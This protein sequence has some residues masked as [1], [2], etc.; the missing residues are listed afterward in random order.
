V[1]RP[2]WRT[3]RAA[4]LACAFRDRGIAVALGG[5]H[6]SGSLAMLP[7][8]APEIRALMERGVAVV[9][10]EVEEKMEALLLAAWEQKLEPLYDFPHERPDLGRAPAPASIAST[11]PASRLHHGDARRESRLPFTCSF[12]AIINVQ[13]RSMRARRAETVA[14]HHRAPLPRPRLRPPLLHRRQ[15]RTQ[16]RTRRH[17]RRPDRA[18]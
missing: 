11:S 14:S 2:H 3:S 8:V 18:P 16:P 13:G 9:A 12:C 5:F 1:R 4:D 7:G 15:L 10:G 6:V 17:S